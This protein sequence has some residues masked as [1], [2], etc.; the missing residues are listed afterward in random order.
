MLVKEAVSSDCSKIAGHVGIYLVTAPGPG[1][2]PGHVG[3]SDGV[4]QDKESS[5]YMSG[6]K[7]VKDT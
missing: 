2:P 1:W 6:I 7:V 3:Q 4:R 5:L